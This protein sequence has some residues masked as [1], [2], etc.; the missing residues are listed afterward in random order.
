MLPAFSIDSVILLL[1]RATFKVERPFVFLTSGLIR[2][3]LQY[4]YTEAISV[5]S[6]CTPL[7]ISR[8]ELG[9]GEGGQE[10]LM[11]EKHE[12]TF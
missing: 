5:R 7:V 8:T 3:L 11:S 6:N 2:R 12:Q 4:L 1:F 10:N 9:G